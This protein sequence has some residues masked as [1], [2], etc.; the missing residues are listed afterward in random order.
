MAML[1][2]DETTSTE[3]PPAPG[4]SSG[5]ALLREDASANTGL[6]ERLRDYADIL[7]VQGADGFRVAAYRRAADT[8]AA[9][10]R[11]AAAILAAEGQ[12]GLMQLPGIGPSIA[13]ALTEMLTTGRWSQLERLRGAL[14]PERL[15]RTIPGVGPE[16]AARLHD[17]LDAETLEALEIAA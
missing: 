4:E 16:L 7:E 8:I 9:L 3:S 11:A 2:R 5:A 17:A 12:S 10:D 14:D 1:T 15:F 6:A 13:P